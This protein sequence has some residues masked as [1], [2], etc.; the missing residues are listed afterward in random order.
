MYWGGDFSNKE[1]DCFPD[2]EVVAGDAFG[3]CRHEVGNMG[4]G[5]VEEWVLLEFVV[6]SQGDEIYKHALR[7]LYLIQ[8][9]EDFD[10]DL[11][12]FLNKSGW[13]YYFYSVRTFSAAW[14]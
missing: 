7:N 11:N 3:D 13:W 4:N 5:G 12:T 2:I 9:L 8:V 1:L 10:D 6:F 14:R